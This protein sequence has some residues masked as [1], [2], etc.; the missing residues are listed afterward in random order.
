MASEIEIVED[1]GVAGG[2][3]MLRN[4]VYTAAAYGDLEKL[5]R[6]V[7]SEGCS[8]SEPDGLGYY[9]LQW[10]ALNNRT[11]AAQ[12][13]IEH[14]GDVNAADHTGQT[15]LHWSA[16]RGAIQVAE[17]F[18]SGGSSDQCCRFVWLSVNTC[19][20]TVWSDGFSLS[21]CY[22]MECRPRRLR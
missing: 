12:Y 4:D 15:A 22:K 3:E 9:A 19:C 17:L 20:S 2:D 13:V 6:L 10:A 21:Y 7:E 5:Q 11:D 8:V 14:G 18:T 16:V 1:E